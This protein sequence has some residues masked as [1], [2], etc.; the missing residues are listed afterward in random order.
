VLYC[1]VLYC[2]LLCCGHQ[3]C[4]IATTLHAWTPARHVLYF[5]SML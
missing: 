2:G 1:G 5:K 4:S 3:L